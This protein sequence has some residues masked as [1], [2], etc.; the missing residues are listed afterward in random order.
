MGTSAVRT[1][2]HREAC[3]ELEKAGRLFAAGTITRHEWCA[4]VERII[5]ARELGTAAPP[6]EQEP[7]PA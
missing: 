4:S 7:A 5:E 3:A 6:A 2:T 1:L